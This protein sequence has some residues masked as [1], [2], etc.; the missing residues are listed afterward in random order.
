MTKSKK[1]SQDEIN[2][3]CGLIHNKIHE[4]EKEKETI[5]ADTS[6]SKDKKENDLKFAENDIVEWNEIFSKVWKKFK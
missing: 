6:L 2:K 5:L 4:L 3:V 1:V